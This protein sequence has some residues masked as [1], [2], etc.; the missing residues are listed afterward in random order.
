MFQT[1]DELDQIE[2]RQTAFQQAKNDIQ[3][4]LTPELSSNIAKATA[5][6]YATNPELTAS[7]ALSGIPVDYQ[8]VHRNSQSQ[9]RK[10][11]QLIDHHEQLWSDAPYVPLPKDA[12]IITL[13]RM[14]PDNWAVHPSRQPDWWDQVDPGAK[15]R[16]LQLPKVTT[17]RDLLSW[18]EMQI[19]KLWMTMTPEQWAQIPGM[20]EGSGGDNGYAVDEKGN[21]L[22]GSFYPTQDL[23]E[24]FPILKT[25]MGLD[26]LPTGWNRAFQGTIEESTQLM[27][28]VGH[29][30]GLPF[31][32]LGLL[33]PD[34][35]GPAGG[36]NLGI[37]RVPS[38]ISIEGIG[39]AARG[40][41]RGAGTALT[42]AQQFGKAMLDYAMTHNQSNGL[43]VLPP[44]GDTEDFYNTVIRGNVISQV[45]SDLANGR[46][47]D[48]GTGF[49]PKG[50]TMDDARMRHDLGLPKIDGKTWTP[51]RAVIQ[52]LVKEGY[53]DKDGY[54][55]SVISGLVDATATVLADPGLFYNPVEGLM[56]AFNLTE[57]G[58]TKLLNSR[59]AD[60]VR[61]GWA[62]ERKA[63]NLSTE[64]EDALTM[65]W[66]ETNKVWK[67]APS[68]AEDV[69]PFA[70]MLPTG[71]A[72]PPEAEQVAQNLARKSIEGKVLS[73]LDKPP[74]PEPYTGTAGTRTS[75]K[76]NLGLLTEDGSGILR[77]NP[78]AIDQM[79]YT[80]DGQRALN[81][82]SS[83]K[84]AGELYDAFNGNIPLGTAVAIQDV[85][86]AA[87]KAGT[88]ADIHQIHKLLVEGAMSGD[89]LYNVAR[90]P[91]VVGQV[92]NETGKT[93]AYWSARSGW[94]MLG[95]MPNSVFFSF[96]D[97]ISSINDMN[98]M[99]V[100][101]R[102]K[103]AQRHSMLD[104]AMR[105]IVS[106]NSK[107][108]FKLAN[109]WMSTI[110][111]P[112][113][114][115]ANV[116]P[117]WAKTVT[118]WSKWTDGVHKLQVDALGNDYPMPWLI[119]GSADILKTIDALNHG[120]LMIGGEDNLRRVLREVSK[121]H[122]VLAPL[123]RST[124]P[125]I[126]KLFED[127]GVAH[128]LLKVQHSWLK[129]VAMGAPLPI[130]M[131]TRVVPDEILRVA[132][133]QRVSP[134]SLRALA[135][136]GHVNY[137]THGEQIILGRQLQKIVPM[138]DHLENNLYPK[139]R[140]AQ[141]LEDIKLA[142]KLRE[143]ISKIEEE[144]GTLKEMKAQRDLYNRRMETSLP[145]AN[146]KL[147]ETSQGLMSNQMDDPR[148]VRYSRS[149]F[150]VTVDKSV[151]PKQWVDATAQ[152]LV[153]MNATPM[154]KEVAKA[155][156]TGDKNEVANLVPR[157]LD[158]DLKE[159][160]NEYRTAIGT[161]SPDFP[162][163]RPDTVSAMVAVIVD[164]IMGRTAGD[165]TALN[166][167]VTGK[168]GDIKIGSGHAY[169]LNLPTAEFR[170]WVKENLLPNPR[171]AQKILHFATEYEAEIQQ[172]D[173]LL[174]KAFSLY[175]N[176]SEKYARNPYRSYQKWQK[177]IELMPVMDKEEAA[178]MAASIDKTDAP[179]W[180]KDDI[181]EGVDSAVGTVTRQQAEILGEMHAVREEDRLLYN[182]NNKS[183]FGHKT[184]LFFAFFDAWKEQWS[185]WTRAMA[186]DPTILEKARLAKEGLSNA[187]VPSWAG[188]EPGRGFLFKDPDTG[189][190]MWAL[191]FSRQVYKF[192]G[193]NAEEQISTKNMSL[194]GQGLPGMFGIGTMIAQ[195]AVPT[196]ATFMGVNNVLFPYGRQLPKTKIAD[197]V[198]PAWA[199]KLVGGATGLL[200]SN[201]PSLAK[202]G[203]VSFLQAMLT[204]DQSLAV[205]G[206]TLNAVLTNYVANSGIVPTTEEERQKILNDTADK[207]NYVSLLK[208]IGRIFLP[209]AS[210]TKYYV[211]NK[212]E[213]V[214]TGA[215][216]DDLRKFQGESKTYGEA[217]QKLLDKYGNGAWIYLSGAS[218]AYPGM[219]PSKEYASWMR[220]NGSLVDKY[221]LVGGYLGPQDGKFDPTAFSEQ[222][223]S[224]YRTPKDITLR[225]DKA[226]ANLAWTLYNQ[227]KYNLIA[228]GA[229]QGLT[230]KQVKNSSIFKQLMREKSDELK[231]LYPSWNPAATAG[232]NERELDNQIRQISRMVK[233]KKVLSQPAGKALKEYWDFRTAKIDK[234]TSDYPQFGNNVWRKSINTAPLR[235]KLRKKGEEL[236]AKYPEFKA[237]WTI[238]LSQE[239]LPPEMGQ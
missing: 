89:P 232:E 43:L 161:E 160:L 59:A 217:V 62:A 174:T 30:A 195:I 39:A 121:T 63:A 151:H 70:G 136:T 12:N 235:D 120:F 192:L 210:L 50:K 1:P 44:T 72:L 71:T 143:K 90:V 150:G 27:N 97:P 9:L 220:S 86:D 51:G 182:F 225:Q 165:T 100:L 191:P 106:G 29:I 184:A 221:S 116:D 111:G 122:E 75:A 208:G 166:A 22:P 146:R 189:Q 26:R 203:F 105:A 74:L 25:L 126:Q 181:R 78:M 38:R 91:G 171:S 60:I 4:R 127:K 206:G 10:N 58:A 211:E 158:G 186:M 194:L 115:A 123:K 19:A 3:P 128:W 64:Y 107:D 227:R 7:L 125:T 79:P 57:M 103:P 65:V 54:T 149:R 53:I 48:I 233:D 224:G 13:M 108:K 42:G 214:T 155:L 177:I 183:Y 84:N 169:D 193:L 153:K 200:T 117:K 135:I 223:A 104:M 47:V 179:Q 41:V 162:L 34:H 141:M 142:E 133:T 144:F 87:N 207:A 21:R 85:V 138:I 80:R 2:A 130:R 237:L 198:S 132:V 77:P 156:L 209:A 172:K 118:R 110:V 8:A 226:L 94:R 201:Y 197:Y 176:A 167:I 98:R 101:L 33:T 129:P 119:D 102:V 11:A 222:R 73:S 99:M 175:R 45:V 40:A 157:F 231:K 49:F 17:A 180:L 216:M 69:P 185:V 164:N 173:R 23:P 212:I 37:I 35:I 163:N 81:K 32:F 199:Q 6:S 92:L 170:A 20:L 124:N 82:L 234:V 46:K 238:V 113:L 5:G 31:K 147:A 204:T 152:D 36:I 68:A 55:A 28:T 187:E 114:K 178:K 215:V 228:K 239:F 213:N 236:V 93:A 66:D 202:N 15:W 230:E 56:K 219:V 148:V 18:D 134:E 83:F 16:N 96:E 168:L 131:V 159:M 76:N 109:E 88:T 67:Y 154:F 229:E 14:G 112:R 190:D 137:T 24:K 139:L 218:N 145:G 205:D 140:R 61:E 188:G 52:P 95:S 196:T